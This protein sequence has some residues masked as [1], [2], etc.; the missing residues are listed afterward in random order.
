MKIVCKYCFRGQPE[1]DCGDTIWSFI[2]NSAEISCTKD[3]DAVLVAA[4]YKGEEIPLVELGI[5][6]W[7]D[8]LGIGE[9]LALYAARSK[10]HY[11][12]R[13]EAFRKVNF[14]WVGE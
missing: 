9:R 3:G 6:L 8:K 5:G 14:R 7:R 2:A 10:S 11:A 4:I 13:I 12:S 1:A